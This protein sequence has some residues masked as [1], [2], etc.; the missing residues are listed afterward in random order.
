[1]RSTLIIAACAVAVTACSSK[2]S[3][4]DSAAAAES[5]AAA[6]AAAAPPPAAPSGAMATVVDA[7]GKE[8]GML[9]LADA[10]GG[11]TVSGTLKG[12][13]PGDHGIHI[14]TVGMCEAP[15]YTTAGGHWNPSN[16]MHGK[17]N[18][19]GPHFGDMMNI[20]VGADSSAS[21]Q[22]TTSGGTLHAADMLMDA[23]GAAVVVHAK[24]DDYKTDPSGN[25]GDR[26][27]CGTIKG[28]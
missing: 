17:D 9:M 18:A 13:A 11:I 24:A 12:L 1:M 4:A 22:L 8:L 2:D 10:A 21:V 15:A 28:S 7:A 23:D 20:T 5:A 6:A 16:K 3:A 19:Q 25:S 14:H 27:A 26:V